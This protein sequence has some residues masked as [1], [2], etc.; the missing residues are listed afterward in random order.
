MDRDGQFRLTYS[1]MFDPPAELH[2]RF[3][4]APG[5]VRAA[6]GHRNDAATR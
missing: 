3:D 5:R 6:S 1:T 4:A 2:E